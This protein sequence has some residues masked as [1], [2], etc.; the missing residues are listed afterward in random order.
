MIWVYRATRGPRAVWAGPSFVEACFTGSGG[1]LPALSAFWCSL[2]GMSAM[3][4]GG[5]IEELE[6]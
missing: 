4:G 1:V 2:T 3:T 6:E 5:D